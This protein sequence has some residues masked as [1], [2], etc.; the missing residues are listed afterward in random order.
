MA[1]SNDFILSAALAELALADEHHERSRYE[2]RLPLSP[3]WDGENRVIKRETLREARSA[4]DAVARLQARWFHKVPPEREARLAVEWHLASLADANV[5]VAALPDFAQESPFAPEQAI[6]RVDGRR[7]RPDFFRHLGTILRLRKALKG[8]PLSS[9]LELGAGTGD[10]ARLVLGW[11]P[12][13]RY[14]IIDLPDTLV[15]SFMH[16][17][18]SFPELE[19]LFVRE[20]T[21]REEIARARVVFCPVSLQDR[22][23]DLRFDLF[24]NTSSLGEMRIETVRHWFDVIQ[25]RE[26]PRWLLSVNRFLNTQVPGRHEWRREENTSALCFDAGWTIRD[27]ELEPRFAR[28]PYAGKGARN[29]LIIAAD[30]GVPDDAS[31]IAASIALAE[32]A[33]CGSWNQPPL[34]MTCQDN[35]LASDLTMSGILFRLWNSVRLDRRRDNLELMLDYLDTLMRRED[36]HFEEHVHYAAQLDAL[37]GDGARPGVSRR[38][39]A[40]DLPRLVSSIEGYN[41]VDYGRRYLGVPQSLGPL[42]LAEQ[43]LSALPGLIT[44]ESIETVD[45]MIRAAVRPAPQSAAR[46]S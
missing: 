13:A 23:L 38:R 37:A 30:A 43:D 40:A 17:R 15:F 44:G 27:W 7:Y 8:S 39:A 4:P 20:N 22:V 35:P 36:R 19:H 9:V 25:R 3:I 18:L 46:G 42:D 31:R 24:V 26:R 12:A 5:D 34:D 41:I 10:L 33:A 1:R 11:W 2:E 45:A 14:V 21:S 16:L 29:L 32:D 6:L 28:S